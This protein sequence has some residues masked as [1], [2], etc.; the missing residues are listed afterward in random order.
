MMY[1]AAFVYCQRESCAIG[2]NEQLGEVRDRLGEILAAA[3]VL[4]YEA[5]VITDFGSGRMDWLKQEVDFLIHRK[6][7]DLKFIYCQRGAC[8]IGKHLVQ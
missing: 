1:D 7:L 3:S 8:L 6:R 4:R 5:E 2:K